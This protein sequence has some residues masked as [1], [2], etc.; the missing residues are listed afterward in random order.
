VSGNG[1]NGKML[2]ATVIS[3]FVKVENCMC[4]LTT[5][6]QCHDARQSTVKNQK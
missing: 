2:A 5:G 6:Q 3:I 4:C 1:R